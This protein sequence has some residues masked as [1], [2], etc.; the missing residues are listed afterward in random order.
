M[1][2]G[3]W[4]YTIDK[5]STDIFN[6]LFFISIRMRLKNKHDEMKLEGDLRKSQ[7]ACQQLDTQ[8]ASLLPAFSLVVK[9]LDTQ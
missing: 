8:K 6:V 5:E 7:R 2:S 4:S 9:C 3:S 1:F